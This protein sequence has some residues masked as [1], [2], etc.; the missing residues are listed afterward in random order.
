MARDD[1]GFFGLYFRLL[2]PGMQAL[3]GQ[4]GGA[5]QLAWRCAQCLIAAQAVLL[6]QAV[7]H[8][9]RLEQPAIR[10][11]CICGSQRRTKRPCGS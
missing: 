6:A 5:F 2:A 7:R 9:P 11:F 4:P 1:G 8:F 10:H 3:L